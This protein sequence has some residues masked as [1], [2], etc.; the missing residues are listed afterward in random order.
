ALCRAWP[1]TAA[2]PS[3]GPLPDVPALLLAG[4]ADLRTPREDAAAVAAQLPRGRLLAVPQVGHSVLSWADDDSCQGRALRRFLR[5]A[6]VRDCPRPTG[7]T[8]LPPTRLAPAS[9]D[10]LVP[11]AGLPPRVGRTVAAL[12]ETYDDLQERSLVTVIQFMDSDWDIDDPRQPTIGWG[13]LRGGRATF[14]SRVHAHGYEV[15]P[16]VRV[17]GIGRQLAEDSIEY[18]YTLRVW[19][20]AAARGTVRV[21]AER[22][23]GRLGGR[24]VRVTLPRARATPSR[25]AA[26]AAAVE[27]AR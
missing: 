23:V 6:S 12:R 11:A 19:G 9:F 25:A 3:A 7:R 8:Q 14:D 1:E 26:I 17:T 4:E 10:T 15:V 18:T 13:G 16:G 21:D 24:A 20:P 5:G 27:T 22:I 2:A